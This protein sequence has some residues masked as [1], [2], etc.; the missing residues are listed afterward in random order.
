MEAKCDITAVI[1]THNRPDR[2]TD[3]LTGIL[4][5]SI[6]CNRY[7]VLVVDNSSDPEMQA[8]CYAMCHNEPRVKYLLE[9]RLGLARARN[10]AL[11]HVDTEFI[12]FIDDDAS[13]DHR[14]L[15]ELLTAFKATNEQIGVVGGRVD[16]IWE[17]PVP[18]WL[19]GQAYRDVQDL[20]SLEWR[21]HVRP[22]IG[23]L[24]IVNWGDEMR[25]I[26]D[27]EW[28]A[29]TNICFRTALL[30]QLGGFDEQLGRQGQNTLLSNEESAAMRALIRNGWL[31]I[32]APAARVS[33]R[34]P[35]Q[36]L[37]QIWFAKR[38]AWQVV[39][40]ILEKGDTYDFSHQ[41]ARDALALFKAGLPPGADSL[42]SLLK[43]ADSP[44]GFDQQVFA[45]A[46]LMR[47]L[48]TG[49]RD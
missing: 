30:K 2:L 7:S 20:R 11:R 34:V 18:R 28:L 14:W 35:A 48:L 17:A 47:L 39:S 1:C 46:A 40:D 31:A 6:G 42:E 44:Q 33:H 22:M 24:S 43:P 25:P 9:P 29:G 21:N 45:I 41:D 8:Q 37:E 27:G 3:A 13:A 12:A 38:L 10:T 26:R 15:E 5:Q 32:Y 23:N 4:N 16:P 19:A 49:V 36:R